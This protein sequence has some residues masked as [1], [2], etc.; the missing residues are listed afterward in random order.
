[1][2]YNAVLSRTTE[3]RFFSDIYIYELL[4]YAIVADA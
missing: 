2:T 1:M 3:R 4:M